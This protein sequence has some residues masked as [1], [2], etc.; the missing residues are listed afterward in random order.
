M[1]RICLY[2]LFASGLTLLTAGCAHV[3]HKS[4]GS[5]VPI[6]MSS[7]AGRD[8]DKVASFDDSQKKVFFL[9]HL[10]P[11]SSF[12]G[13][14]MAE[15]HLQ[16]SDGIVNLAINTSYDPLDWLV[17]LLT[18]GLVGTLDIDVHGDLIKFKEP[19][20]P[21]PPPQTNINVQ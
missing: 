21:N 15:Q 20:A 18:V 1:N 3:N 11:A 4:T 9:W 8:Y 16:Q 12:N 2:L 10:I 19:P 5:T 13:V 7:L 14:E 6:S 17:S